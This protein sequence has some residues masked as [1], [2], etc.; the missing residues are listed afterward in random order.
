VANPAAAAKIQPLGYS[1]IMVIDH[2]QSVIVAGE[3]A[4]CDRRR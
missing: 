4:E 2:G 3:S 1:N